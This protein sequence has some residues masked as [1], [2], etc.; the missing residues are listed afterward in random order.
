MATF[1]GVVK[2]RIVDAR[3]AT[4]GKIVSV[5]KFAGDLVKKGDLLAALDRK[6]PQTTL[7]REL[8]DF[9]KVRADFEIFAQKYPDPT[10]VIDKYLK[11]EKQATLNAA[12]KNVEL[13]KAV[14][15]QCDLF[16]PVDGVVIDDSSVVPGLNI[17]PASSSFKIIDSSSYY[18]EVEIGEKDI[19]NFQEPK[20][21]EIRF[22]SKVLSGV[23]GSKVL[24]GKTSQILSDS[25]KFFVK[26]PV[27][28][29][30]LLINMIVEIIF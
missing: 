24:T 20:N 21:A 17:T 28:S 4:S 11:T 19:K 18:V 10:E 1:K 5:K 22:E 15:D 26:I 6:V 14:A 27:A 13:A 7:D 2:A 16:S 29:E 25:K 3:F 23:E 9:E 8:A 30:Y 12:V